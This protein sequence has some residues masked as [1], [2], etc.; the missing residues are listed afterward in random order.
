MR[1]RFAPEVTILVEDV[2]EVLFAERQDA[3]DVLTMHAPKEAL[4]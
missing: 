4:A 1:A 3:V 2:E